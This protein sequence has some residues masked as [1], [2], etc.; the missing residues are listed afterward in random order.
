MTKKTIKNDRARSCLDKN[1]REPAAQPFQFNDEQLNELGEQALILAEQ[2][3]LECLSWDD[4]WRG[5]H[6]EK[7]SDQQVKAEFE[8]LKAKAERI[9]TAGAEMDH[10]YS[11]WDEHRRMIAL[12]ACQTFNIWK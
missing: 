3:N 2:A 12:E 10:E 8:A 5:V 9:L 1:I 11:N 7:P 6:P 4:A